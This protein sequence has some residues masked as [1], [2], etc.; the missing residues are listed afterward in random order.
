LLI[1]QVGEVL[2]GLAERERR[3]LILR[4]GLAGAEALTLQSIADLLQISR[5]RVREIENR[6]LRKLRLAPGPRHLREHA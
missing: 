1:Q 6:A 5:E 2:H 4:F 3:V